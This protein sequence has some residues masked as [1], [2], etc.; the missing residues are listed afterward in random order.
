MSEFRRHM[1]SARLRRLHFY[2]SREAI[3]STVK[4]KMV[5][6]YVSTN[7][8]CFR[9]ALTNTRSGLIGLI[10]GCNSGNCCCWLRLRLESAGNQRALSRGFLE[11]RRLRRCRP[12]ICSSP[13]GIY[14]KQNPGNMLTN[15]TR[16]RLSNSAMIG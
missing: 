9:V 8:K 4:P 1:N 7:H 13:K 14:K 6:V 2:Y 11:L 10:C 5:I 12:T 16:G 3:Y 15:A